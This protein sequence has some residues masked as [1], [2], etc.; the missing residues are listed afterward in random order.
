MIRRHIT[1]HLNQKKASSGMRPNSS[2]REPREFKKAREELYDLNGLASEFAVFGSSWVLDDI[3]KAIKE[4]NTNE[5]P[6]DI[7]AN[8]AL[9]RLL[10]IN[11]PLP[12]DQVPIIAKALE[13]HTH[14]RTPLI[15]PAN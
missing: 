2:P 1:H 8:N 6:E 9:Y 4:K 5:S 13:V 10:N 3:E 7:A 12:P 14:R 11:K 15:S